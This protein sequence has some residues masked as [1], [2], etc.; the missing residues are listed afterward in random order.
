M[1][2]GPH[3]RTEGGYAVTEA[4]RKRLA[5]I[6]ETMTGSHATVCL[7]QYRFAKIEDIGEVILRLFER[8][9]K[10]CIRIQQR[11]ARRHTNAAATREREHANAAGR[12]CR[13][14]QAVRTEIGRGHE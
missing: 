1:V 7:L 9:S 2:I 12:A 10:I 3:D 13:L 11:H 6:K 8:L 5:F 4:F 14:S